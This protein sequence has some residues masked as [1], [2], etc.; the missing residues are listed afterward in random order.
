ML[1]DGTGRSHLGDGSLVTSR[2][3]QDVVGVLAR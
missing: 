1:A 3:A 2:L